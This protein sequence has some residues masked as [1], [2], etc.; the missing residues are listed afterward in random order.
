VT[1]DD[2]A[3]RAPIFVPVK[4]AGLRAWSR[5][6]RFPF[7]ATLG[8]VPIA[9]TELLHMSHYSPIAIAI[10]QAG[11][12]VVAI[13]H[14][15]F[16]KTNPLDT[17]GRWLPRYAPMALR[18]LPFRLSRNGG[19]PEIA[20]SMMGGGA[21]QFPLP[22]AS[23]PPERDY[24]QAIEMLERIARG[25]TRLAHAAKLLIAADVLSPLLPLPGRPDE[26]ILMANG[27]RLAAM[28]PNKAAALTAD[29]NLAFELA[30]ASLFS[31]R[32]LN[33]DMIDEESDPAPAP[34]RSFVSEPRQATVDIDAMI[35]QPFV[36]DSSALFSIETFL[37]A[38]ET[39]DDRG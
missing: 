11:P 38:S 35:E 39:G 29:S 20:P 31:L 8:H 18:C 4:H 15:Q 28:A 36:M 16:L 27:A 33:P 13:V 14:P 21:T 30:A 34:E 22:S 1:A 5:P 9:D 23:G 2:A 10:D 24:A 19:D 37:A 3:E 32:L 17:E 6:E 26:L 25:G 12:Q 7:F